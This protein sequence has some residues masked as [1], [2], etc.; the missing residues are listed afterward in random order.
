MTASDSLSLVGRRDRLAESLDALGLDGL[1]VSH[2]PNV[3]YLS[4]F[5]GSTGWLLVLRGESPVL[6]TDS[7]YEEQATAQLS[8]E[9][10]VELAREGLAASLGDCVLRT[11]AGTLGFEPEHVNV[12][13]RRRI[14]EVCGEARWVEAP[15]AVMALRVVKELCEVEQIRQATTVA[16]AALARTLDWLRGGQRPSE[17]TIA[18]RLEF[19]LRIGGSEALPFE[20]IVASGPRSSLPHAEPGD[21][22]IEEGD[23]LMLDF[24]ATVGGYCCDMT[25]TVVLG[26]ASA[27]QR[28]IHAG[29]RAA[30]DAAIE[31]IGVGTRAADVD[32]V[33]R[34]RLAENDW[35]RFFGHSTGHGIGLEVHEDPR[36]SRRSSD[37]LTVGHVVTVEPGVYLP[38][39][40]GVRIEDDVWLGEGGP[41]RLT[42]FSRRL[43]EL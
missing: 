25:R 34:E 27:W 17:R 42:S 9:I 30:Q 41:E 15:A 40:G 18:A 33:A 19:E 12:L 24:G 8:A 14:E 3:R 4:G 22:R 13:D 35:D 29:V 6:I 7:R 26:V 16:E 43:L 32:R 20:V 37:V 11:R 10:E 21:R 1:L 36:L 31:A 28:D 5:T 23:L 2:P 39:R 38:G